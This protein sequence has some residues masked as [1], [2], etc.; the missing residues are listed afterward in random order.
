MMSAL[1]FAMKQQSFVN[2]QARRILKYYDRREAEG[3]QWDAKVWFE[4]ASKRFV[5]FKGVTWREF[6]DTMCGKF[7]KAI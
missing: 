5:Y 6:R 2:R 4:R 3:E 7:W 1:Q